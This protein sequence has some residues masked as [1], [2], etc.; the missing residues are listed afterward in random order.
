MSA[1]ISLVGTYVF[2]LDMVKVSCLTDEMEVDVNM[3]CPCMELGVLGQLDC[4]L[5]DAVEW[6]GLLVAVKEG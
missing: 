6:S 5:V 3:F 4:A 1:T 2:D